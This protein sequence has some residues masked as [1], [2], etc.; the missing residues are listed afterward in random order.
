MP[1]C[2]LA[3]LA[4]QG[5]VPSANLSRILELVRDE[6]PGATSRRTIKRAIQAELGIDT[7][8]GDLIQ[9]LPLAMQN[10]ST[11][12]LYYVHPGALLTFLCCSAVGFRDLIL[13]RLQQYPCDPT[14]AWPFAVYLDEATA[15]NLLRVDNSRKAWCV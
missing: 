2:K 7:P 14:S 13:S 8:C 15:G 3:S 10:G 9:S 12:T 11:Q 5:P 4:G 6:P 1:K